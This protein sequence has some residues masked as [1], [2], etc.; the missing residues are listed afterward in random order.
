[1][2]HFLWFALLMTPGFAG[3]QPLKLD[4]LDKLASKASNTVR[5]TL[6][7]GLLHLAARFLSS[8]DP[9][10]AQIKEIVKGLKGIYV[11]SF[12]FSKTG[13]YA[14]SD[15]E[16]IR[17]Q[18]RDSSWNAIVEV[19]S[20]GKGDGENT[21]V[22][23]KEQDEHFNGLAILVAEPKEL[24]VIHIDG[25]IDM[26]GLEKLSGKFGIPDDIQIKVEKKPK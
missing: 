20:N 15:V 3:A 8:S 13:Q 14:D 10:E 11:R 7:G 9:D 24:T 21:E 25:V 17:S 1:M 26:D 22:Y 4:S 18:L 6:N 16:A 5:V 2:K 19:H 12:E 23:T